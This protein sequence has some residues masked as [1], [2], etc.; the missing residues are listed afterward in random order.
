MGVPKLPSVYQIEAFS[1]CNLR[2]PFCFTGIANIAPNYS[3]SAMS[4]DL[5]RLIVDRDLGGSH[6]IE[7]QFRGEPTLHKNLSEMVSLLKDKVWVGFSTHGGTLHVKDNLQTALNTHYLTI[8]IDAGTKEGY[9]LKRVGGNWDR[10]LAN[11]DAVFDGRSSNKYPCIDLQLIEED[12]GDR[13]WRDELVSLKKLIKE[14]NWSRCLLRTIPNSSVTWKDPNRV[15]QNTELCL[16]PWMSVSIK[17]NGDV[18]P[19]CMAFKDEPDMIYGNLETQSLEEIWNSKEV[20]LFRERHVF[21]SWN[22]AS[23]QFYLPTTCRNCHNRSPALYHDALL[24]GS[25]RNG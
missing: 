24:M 7:L 16:N 25:I 11:I 5:F 2:C 6:F 14:R 3:E 21:A 17:I 15:I 19:C 13:N 8:S 4:M 22:S 1:R 12:S 10:L 18:V 23:G 9:E 20:R